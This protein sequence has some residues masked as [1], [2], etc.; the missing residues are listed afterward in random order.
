MFSRCI[1]MP[2]WNLKCSLQYQ[3]RAEEPMNHLLLQSS[4][5]AANVTAKP[6]QYSLGCQCQKE[7]DSR[8]NAPAEPMCWS[9]TLSARLSPA[10]FMGLMSPVNHQSMSCSHTHKYRCPLAYCCIPQ[11]TTPCRCVYRIVAL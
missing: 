4:T 3:T 7:S 11:K 6:G 10:V 1:M 5:P 2:L 8:E 9:A